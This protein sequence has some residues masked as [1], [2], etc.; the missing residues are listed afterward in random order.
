M[1]PSARSLSRPPHIH[2][3]SHRSLRLLCFYSPYLCYEDGKYC[4]PHT[5]AI[6]HTSFPPRLICATLQGLFGGGKK[7]EP[8][9]P[10]PATEAAAVAPAGSAFAA[11]LYGT[12]TGTNKHLGMPTYVT[13]AAYF[14]AFRVLF[15]IISTVLQYRVR[16][17]SR[18]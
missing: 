11:S 9:T 14:L 8:T 7:E 15:S 6:T 18:G 4:L 10:T 16:C 17:L 1:S 12:G 13:L 2:K 5:T 3:H